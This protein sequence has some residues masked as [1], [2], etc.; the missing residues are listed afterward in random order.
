MECVEEEEE[1]EEEED[2]DDDEDE[3]DDSAEDC[4]VSR[5]C[6]PAESA[7]RS[8]LGDSRGPAFAWL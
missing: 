5:N 7:V 6:A 8:A 3:D 4:A 2:D 1:E